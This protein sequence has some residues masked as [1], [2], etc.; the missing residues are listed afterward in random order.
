MKKEPAERAMAV[1]ISA[2]AV[3]RSAGFGNLTDEFLR[4]RFA[5]PQALCTAQIASLTRS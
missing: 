1:A 5:P 3:A 4:F 2:K